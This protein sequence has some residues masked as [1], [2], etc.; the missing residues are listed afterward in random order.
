MTEE[1]GISELFM[2]GA[3]LFKDEAPLQGKGLLVKQ[4]GDAVFAITADKGT[5]FEREGCMGVDEVEPFKLYCWH[6]GWLAAIVSPYGG[7]SCIG[8]NTEDRLIAILEAEVGSV[9]E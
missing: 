4:L 7:G 2:L 3:R 6:N 1:R 9:R 8:L 5:K